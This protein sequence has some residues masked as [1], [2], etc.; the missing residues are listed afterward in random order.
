[1]YLR[2]LNNKVIIII[3]I[4]IIKNNVMC[5]LEPRQIKCSGDQNAVRPSYSKGKS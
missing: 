2:N 5:P 1:M 3:V 4:I